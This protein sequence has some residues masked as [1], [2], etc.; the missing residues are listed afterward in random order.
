MT[1][2]S[3]LTEACLAANGRSPH[4]LARGGARPA[5]TGEIADMPAFV[6]ALS[7]WL[8]S[9]PQAMCRHKWVCGESAP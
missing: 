2:L 1:G 3:V 5:V 9:D 8:G 7:E 4:R 6:L